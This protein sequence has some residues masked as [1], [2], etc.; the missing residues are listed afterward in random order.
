MN[1]N[2][3]ISAKKGLRKVRGVKPEPMLKFL[4]DA[5]KYVD[6]IVASFEVHLYSRRRR[7]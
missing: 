4:V 6:E 1:D 3:R 5:V 2:M 7:A